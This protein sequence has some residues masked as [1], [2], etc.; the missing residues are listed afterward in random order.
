MN[1]RKNSGNTFQ[2]IKINK[3]AVWADDLNSTG[4]R[5]D[6]QTKK[7]PTQAVST[8]V[9]RKPNDFKYINHQLNDSLTSRTHSMRGLTPAPCLTAS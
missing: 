9:Y 7:L 6:S 8:R 4:T 2:P 3:I 1:D 5:F